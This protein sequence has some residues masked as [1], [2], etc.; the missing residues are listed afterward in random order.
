MPKDQAEDIK[1]VRI[2]IL[3]ESLSRGTSS[4]KDQRFVNGYFDVLKNSVTNKPTYFF[5]KRP[6][7]E[8][9]SQPSGGAAAGRGT[10]SWRGSIYSC[11]GTKLYKNTTDLGVTLTTSSGLVSFEETRPSASAPVLACS[12]G[13]SLYVIDTSDG[14]TVLNNVAITSSSVANPTV[15][16]TA[17]NHG[18]ATGNKV[19]LRNH[20]GSTPT[21]NGTVYTVT[22]TGLTTFTIPVNVTVGGTG[23]TIGVFP[24]PN[25]VDLIYADGYLYLLKTDG[26]LVNC[27][28]DDAR[29]WDASKFIVPIMDNGN[30]V[31]IARQANFIITFTEQSVQAFYNN[32][33][34]SGSPLNNYEQAMLQVGCLSKNTIVKEE[35]FVTWVGGSDTGGIT[36][37]Q[38]QGLANVKDLGDPTIARILSAEESNISSAWADMVR[39]AGHTFYVLTLPNAN[40]T[41]VYDYQT[42]VWF[43]WAGSDGN[44]FPIV[45]FVHH[46]NALYGMHITN[47]K[48]YK[49][50]PTVYQD[51]S[52]N[53]QV[54]VRLARVDFD[55]SNRKFVRS[56]ELIGDIQASTTPVS[57]QYSDDDFVTLSTARTL[58]MAD[59]KPSA[60]NLG[61]FSRRS[62]QL[63]Y[64]G[65]NPLR[66]EALQLKFRLGMS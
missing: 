36:V 62:W 52:T 43:E 49:I 35:S 34:A 31:G 26:S 45:D 41:F 28:L 39:I 58:D 18:L 61:N 63:S 57:L 46:S 65:A 15:I 50:L 8:S 3:G 55:T 48:I 25:L 51:D 59:P 38:L 22:V 32:A 44:Y 7:L 53:F 60:L 47:G 27:D 9:Y 13:T 54:L 30:P 16:T 23:G 33:N 24:T 66:L 42:E 64:S 2:P 56:L 20:S 10:Y 29:T 14:V 21:L 4:S 11:L 12:D 19:I 1:T 40:R 17:T 5:T 37:Y 6:G